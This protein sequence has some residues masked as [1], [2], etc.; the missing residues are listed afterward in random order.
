MPSKSHT[1]EHKDQNKH[2]TWNMH[3]RP[4]S[5]NILLIREQSILK[6][7]EPYRCRP[8]LHT[9]KATKSDASVLPRVWTATQVDP[10]LLGTSRVGL[11]LRNWPE[12]DPKLHMSRVNSVLEMTD[13]RNRYEKSNSPVTKLGPLF[14]Y[15][16]NVF[17]NSKPLWKHIFTNTS[18]MFS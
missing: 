15:K 18:F 13:F 1:I 9:K 5:S 10:G 2:V 17:K 14:I 7:H 11:W 6:L 3:L 16:W 8:L 12:W 4:L